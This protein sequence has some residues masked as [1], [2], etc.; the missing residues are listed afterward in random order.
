MKSKS[1]KPKLVNAIAATTKPMP[2]EERR[3]LIA[4]AA[5]FKALGRNF[6]GGS[7]VDDWFAAEREIDGMLLAGETYAHSSA[8]PA[9]NG[10]AR[11]ATETAESHARADE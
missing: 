2:A 1:A 4:E 8:R 7:A 10:T 5:Y 9:G 3:R 6:E 11:S